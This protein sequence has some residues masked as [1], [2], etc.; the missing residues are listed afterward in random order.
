MGSVEKRIRGIVPPNIDIIGQTPYGG[1]RYC[2]QP[3]TFTSVQHYFSDADIMQV[4]QTCREGTYAVYEG[5]DWSRQHASPFTVRDYY[6]TACDN[7]DDAAT[8]PVARYCIDPYM[9]YTDV[10]DWLSMD[11][12]V[13]FLGLGRL[14]RFADDLSC[15]AYFGGDAA[16]AADAEAQAQVA[17][18]AFGG[19][20]A[21]DQE[22]IRECSFNE[23]QVVL[24]PSVAA[25]SAKWPFL[26][27]HYLQAYTRVDWS[28]EGNEARQAPPPPS[29]PPAAFRQAFG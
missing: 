26:S 24:R 16:A 9:C 15:N 5:W 14:Q 11:E 13:R 10:P 21:T 3:S 29:P 25:Q 4:G 23:H 27:D 8:C 2:K 22:L 7:K 18:A 12:L 17:A 19:G 6:G 1:L 20:T 28:I